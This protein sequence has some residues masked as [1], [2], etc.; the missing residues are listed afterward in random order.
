MILMVSNKTRDIGILKALGTSKRDIMVI[1]ILQGLV[2]GSIAAASGFA[3]GTVL[4]LYLQ[5]AEFSF[6]GGLALEIVY[7]PIFT[8]TSSLFAI[9]LG[10]AAAV[11]PA[12]RASSLEPVDAMRHS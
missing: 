1:F 5:S 10:V 3:V 4:A 11:Y 7:D 12:Y 6:G 8:L 2:I 9:V